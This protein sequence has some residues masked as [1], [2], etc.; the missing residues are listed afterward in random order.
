MSSSQQVEIDDESPF[1]KM[2]PGFISKEDA[3]AKRAQFERY[4]QEIHDK[5]KDIEESF[6][7]QEDDNDSFQEVIEIGTD[8][9]EKIYILYFIGR[10]NPPHEFHLKCIFELVEKAKKLGTKALILLGSG[11]RKDRE[12]KDGTFF[13]G[14]FAD[15]LDFATKKIFITKILISN[16]YV[17]GVD[18]EITEMINAMTDVP[19]YAREVV[20]E[21]IGDP[22]NITHVKV[23]IEQ[24]AGRKEGDDKKLLSVGLAALSAVKEKGQKSNF[25]V[26]GAAAVQGVDPGQGEPL[27]ATDIRK[28]AYRCALNTRLK[29]DKDGNFLGF[30]KWN[31]EWG[32]FYRDDAPTIFN[33]IMRPVKDYLSR[34]IPQEKVII[35]LETYIETKKLPT[36]NALFKMIE[37]K[38]GGSK[39]RP[40]KGGSKRKPNKT[41]KRRKRRTRRSY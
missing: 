18:F 23:L 33:G 36:T 32:G 24:F 29:T 16:R 27:G 35:L 11:P 2:K 5:N 21:K 28:H 12:V 8:N 19:G 20:T 10:C 15:P 6:E 1:K 26:E 7:T 4:L 14:S 22:P 17:E 31:A 9:G 41:Q 39:R 3:N 37:P 13:A 30:D 34:R 40:R 25:D 38:I